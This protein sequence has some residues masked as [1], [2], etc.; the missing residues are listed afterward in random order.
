[1]NLTH[2]VILRLK[3]KNCKHVTSQNDPTFHRGRYC[4]LIIRG[5]SISMDFD[6]VRVMVFNT[7]FNNFSVISWR[8]IFP[9]ILIGLG[10]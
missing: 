5:I 1:M 4:E 10:L 6:R 2:N 7:T 8:S 9:W 3:M